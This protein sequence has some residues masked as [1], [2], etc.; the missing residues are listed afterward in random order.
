MVWRFPPERAGRAPQAS[1]HSN[2]AEL[3]AVR[4]ALIVEVGG[5]GAEGGLEPVSESEA[6]FIRV[7]LEEAATMDA[8]P[9][10]PARASN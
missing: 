2:S 4:L 7:V 9:A 3:V 8:T 6:E 10:L 1:R 5:A